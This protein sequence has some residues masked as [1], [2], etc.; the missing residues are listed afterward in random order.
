VDTAIVGQ[1]PQDMIG[2]DDP[3][4]CLASSSPSDTVAG[5]PRGLSSYAIA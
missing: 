4:E 2:A 1:A 5:Q 3:R